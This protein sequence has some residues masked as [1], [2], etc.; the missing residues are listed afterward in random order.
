MTYPGV[1]RANKRIELDRQ[2][3]AD[4]ETVLLTYDTFA[5]GMV[6]TEMLSFLTV[7]EGYPDFA[8][9]VECQ[10]GEVLVPGD[11]PMVNAGVALWDQTFPETGALPRVRGAQVFL[12]VSS[13]TSYR[14]RFR[15]AFSG[16]IFRNVSLLGVTPTPTP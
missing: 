9:G 15:F 13:A 2:T 8:Y 6:T 11:Y 7:F 4:R 12:V 5:P 1:R 14:L 3:W 10:E 16:V